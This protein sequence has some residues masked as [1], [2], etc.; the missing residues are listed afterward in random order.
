MKNAIIFGANSDI[1]NKLV[2]KL[3]RKGFNLCLCSRNKELLELNALDIRN[4]YQVK[5]KVEIIDFTIDNIY[6]HETVLP[7]IVHNFAE[8]IDLICIAHGFLPKQELCSTKINDELN[9]LQVNAVSIITICNYF[10]NY[11]RRQK[12]GVIAVISSVAG[13]RGRQ[14]NYSYGAAKGLL[15]TYLQG[16]RNSLFPDNVHVLTIIPGFVDSKMTKEFTKGFL[17]V[18]P[19]KVADDIYRAIIK[20]KDIIFTP[21]FWKYIMKIVCLIPERIFKRMKL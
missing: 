17:W 11:M 9:N 4:R 13:L 14:S 19:E 2:H 12:D 1:A 3:A 21:W 8:T 18:K 10:A 15:N 16:L 7:Q 20:K 5:V 6:L